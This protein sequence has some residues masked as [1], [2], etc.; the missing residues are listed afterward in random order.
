MRFPSEVLFFLKVMKRFQLLLNIT[1]SFSVPWIAAQTAD[2][3]IYEQHG[4]AIKKEQQ[5]IID[6]ALTVREKFKGIDKT[7]IDKQLSEPIPEAIKLT[8]ALTKPMSSEQI[9]E[10]ARK[11]NLRVGY[12]YLCTSCDDWHI[13]LAGGYAI[14]EDVIVT[15]DHVVVNDKKMRDGFFVVVDHEGN[16]AIAS[17]ILARSPAMDAA[18]IKVVGAKFTPVPLNSEVKQGTEA[19]CFSYPLQQQ[20]YFS[21]GVVNRFFWN[22][23]YQGQTRDSIDALLHLRVNFT[24]DW[25]P[26]SSGSPLFD[27]SGNVIGHVSTISGLGSGKNKGPMITL[28]TGIPALSVRGLANKMQEP[29]EVQRIAKIE[30]KKSQAPKTEPTPSKD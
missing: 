10:H 8:A 16:V 3:L 24:T 5:E 13:G 1:L 12:C 7:E 30:T 15:C 11:A 2:T 28:R 26:G 14:A 6:K 25:A 9:A 29:A 4:P 23:F 20:G 17:A 21:A 19:F 27:S 18:I 22:E